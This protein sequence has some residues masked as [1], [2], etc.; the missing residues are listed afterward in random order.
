MSSESGDVLL[1][2]L[3]NIQKDLNQI[4]KS[5]DQALTHQVRNLGLLFDKIGI[6]EKPEVL[7]MMWKMK[8]KPI[9]NFAQFSGKII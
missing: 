6:I 5:N 2:T 7:K 9:M 1:V 8:S 4:I 3:T